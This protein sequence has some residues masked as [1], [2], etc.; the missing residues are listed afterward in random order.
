MDIFPNFTNIPPVL[1]TAGTNHTQETE[2]S[3][4]EDRST[5]TDVVVERVGEPAADES[6]CDV[7]YGIL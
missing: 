6:R 5:T 4:K 7:G 3:G 1:R 2:D